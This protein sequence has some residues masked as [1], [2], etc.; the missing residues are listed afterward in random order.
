MLTRSHEGPAPGGARRPPA[1]PP[2][3]VAQ[4]GRDDDVY[5]T[6]NLSGIVV[7]TGSVV[8]DFMPTILIV[9]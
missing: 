4:R 7:G 6:A 8:V 1:E 5:N 2:E 3:P 9:R